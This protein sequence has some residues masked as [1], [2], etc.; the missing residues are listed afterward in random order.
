MSETVP[1]YMQRI[2]GY[3]E[4]QQPLKIQSA[5][6]KKLER[7]LKGV[8]AAKLRKRPAPDKWSV[9]EIIAHLAD[10]EIVTGFRLRQI[11]GT[12]G[13]PIPPMIRKRGPSPAV[14]KNAMH[15]NRSRHSACCAKRTSRY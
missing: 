2:L 13:T 3:A 5:S 15:A 11:L 8:P 12:P 4:G 10:S 7:L 1:Q 14:T 9:A 6:A